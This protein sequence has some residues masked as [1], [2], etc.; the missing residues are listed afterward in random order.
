M[1]KLDVELYCENCRDFDPEG[2]KLIGLCFSGEDIVETVVTCR[3][4][5]RCEA[6]ANHIKKE[7]SK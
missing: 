2:E 5:Y 7:L 6:I 3:H 4:K 1:I